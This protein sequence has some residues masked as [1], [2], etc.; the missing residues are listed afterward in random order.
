M[1]VMILI[2]SILAATILSLKAIT[3]DINYQQ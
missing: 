3:Y 2:S 1:L